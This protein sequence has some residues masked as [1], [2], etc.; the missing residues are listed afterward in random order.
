MSF[1]CVRLP[2]AGSVGLEVEADSEEEAIEKAFQAFVIVD[3]IDDI[4]AY[5]SLDEHFVVTETH[6]PL[7]KATVKKIENRIEER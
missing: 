2:V 1:Y 5:R 6:T 4:E 7:V 3:Q